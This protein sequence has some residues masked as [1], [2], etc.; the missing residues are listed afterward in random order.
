MPDIMRSMGPA[1]LAVMAAVLFG[2]VIFFI[3]L[4]TRLSNSDMSLLYGELSSSD[5]GAIA[6]KLEQ[7]KV[8]YQMS[9]DGTQ[10]LV[11]GSDVGR[12]RMILAEEGLPGEGS[13]GYE[14]FDQQSSFGTTDFV[15]NIN[16]VRALEGELAKTIKTLKPVKSARI[17]LVLPKRQLFSREE[18]AATAS[19][20]LKLNPGQSLNKEQVMAVQHMVAA[21]VPQLKPTRVS[22]VDEQGKLLANGVDESENPDSMF[23]SSNA[24]E[25]RLKYE[26]R[27]SKMIED[28]I[29]QIVG[30]GKVRANV[31]ADLDF[32]RISTN[33]EEYD[34]EGQVVRST[35]LIEENE[36]D[37][38]GGSQGV[39][40]QNNL[41]G[42]NQGGAAGGDA[43]GSSL[44]RTEEVTNFE[45]SKTIKNHI[46]ES[47]QVNRLSLA[48]LVDGT[49]TTDAE[50]K[51]T[52]TPRSAEELE[53]IE[54]L[55]RSAIGFDDARGDSLEVINLQ[56]AETTAETVIDDMQSN[57][58]MGF[59]KSDLLDIAETV[60]LAIVALLVVL[61]VLQP[62]VNKLIESTAANG[63][64]SETELENLIA[65]QLQSQ[66]ILAGPQSGG[67]NS[68]GGGTDD[69]GFMIDMD[70]VEGRVKASSMQ[71][72]SEL[73]DKHPQ[74]TVSVLRSWMYQEN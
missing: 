23:M 61:L 37:S 72:I 57:L 59:E 15:Q 45:I 27:M 42:L 16:Q 9:Q 2:I 30:F 63:S 25:M 24:E 64:N 29:G 74:E 6:A 70:K 22:I 19:V 34:P 50:G 13:V 21:A 14:I 58:I 48:V 36:K 40:V 5:A 49:Y 7:V 41:P 67:G 35:Q 53:K 60:T 43:S 17:H 52:Y 65:S 33:S 56:F 18:Q 66:G 73:V 68:S 47:G 11:S 3:F 26:Q 28:L 8:P 44:N 55:V 51:E 54:N 10:I 12:A 38:T 32:D 69:G 62:L 4:T 31:T 20:F 1:R 46:R 39:T 71:K